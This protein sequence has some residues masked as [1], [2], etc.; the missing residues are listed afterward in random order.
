M[1]R[2]DTVFRAEVRGNTVHGYGAVFDQNTT[3][4]AES[5]S[6]SVQRGAFTKALE[7][8]DDV[9]GLWGHDVNHLLG[10]SASGTLRLSEDEHGLAFELDLP[11][12]QLGR[13]VRALLER[14]DIRGASIGF[15]PG[16]VQRA[17]GHVVHTEIAGLHD[18]S[19]VSNPA[20]VGTSAALRNAD[21]RTVRER[22]ITARHRAR[23]GRDDR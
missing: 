2:F 16:Q 8:D 20:Y 14:G 10:R 1:R 18:V 4:I 12:T 11:D 3:R 13:D 17:G 19:L 22:L 15:V 6:E 23:F 7:S 5:R 21:V 9:L